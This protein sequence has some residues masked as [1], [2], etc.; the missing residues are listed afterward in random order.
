MDKTELGCLRAIVL[1]NPGQ[2]HRMLEG[3]IRSDIGQTSYQPLEYGFMTCLCIFIS[4]KATV[5]LWHRLQFTCGVKGFLCDFVW[6]W[7]CIGF[8]CKRSFKPSGG[9][10]AEGKSV[11]FVGIVHKTEI[12]RPA[13]Q[14]GDALQCRTNQYETPLF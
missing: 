7:L 13:R 4:R 1:F 8:R 6:L 5:T 9:W 14:V 12:P 2:L 11:C 10:G 3:I